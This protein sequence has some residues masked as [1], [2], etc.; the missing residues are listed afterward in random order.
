[1]KQHG[2]KSND[3]RENLREFKAIHE[4]H[5]PVKILGT[6]QINMSEEISIFP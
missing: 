1:M 2:P 6:E 5:H 3:W 4:Y